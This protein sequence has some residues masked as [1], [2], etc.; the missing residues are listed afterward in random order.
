M[1]HLGNPKN[2]NLLIGPI[3]LFFKK[4]F[5]PEDFLKWLFSKYEYEIMWIP[6][7]YVY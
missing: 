2:E 6:Q 4:S 5:N 7:K 1:E 3:L